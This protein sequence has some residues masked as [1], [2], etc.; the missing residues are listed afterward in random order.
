VARSGNS[1]PGRTLGVLVGIIA[2]LF[3]VVGAGMVFSSAQWTPKLAL[4][5]EG[6]TQIVLAAVPQ[7]GTSGQITQQTLDEAVKIIRQRINGSGV[8]EAEITTQ[9]G[10]NIVVSLPGKTDQATRDSVKRAAAL[11]FRPVLVEQASQPAATAS[12]TGSVSPSASPSGSAKASA[13]PSAAGATLKS[14]AA[15]SASA[16][17]SV[18]ATASSNGMA[19]VQGLLA[20]TPTPSPTTAIPTG[21]ATGAASGAAVASPGTTQPKPT[22]ASDTNWIDASVAEQAQKLD[23]AKQ[24]SLKGVA[25]SDPKKP[26]ATC[27]TDGQAMYILGPAELTGTDIGNAS[28]SL[29]TN[30]QGATGINWQVNLTF[31]NDGPAKF[32]KV[33]SRLTALEAPRNEFAIVLDG[34][35]VSAPRTN[36]AIT[37][38]SAQITGNFTQDQAQALANQLKF[39]ALPISFQELTEQ[40]ISATLGGEQLQRGLL[41]GLIGL[42]LVVLYSLAQYRALGLVTVSSLVIA[43][44]I[45]YGLV[46]LLGWRQGY[47]LSLAGVAGLIVAI[48]ITADSFIVY[49]ERVR[50][51][52]RDGRGLQTAVENAWARARRTILISD[53][54]SFLAA[55][56]L[57]V[58]AIGSVRGFA[59]TLGLTTLI[60]VLV[61]FLFTH[62]MVV[63][64]SRTRFFGGGHRLS[65]FDAEHLGRA[66]TYTGRGR[67]RAHPTPTRA[68]KAATAGAGAAATTGSTIAERRAAA[69]RAEREALMGES[70]TGRTDQDLTPGVAD[71]DAVAGETAGT[72]RRDA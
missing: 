68:T 42:A 44:T 4:D 12:P 55:T 29:E 50:D 61:V 45:T 72:S 51:E 28:A 31:K 46:L 11:E 70:G 20:A 37:G 60:D 9:G 40:N 54:V 19:I 59:F 24:A 21:S 17:P 16:T 36:E 13:S 7:T 52:V 57:Y 53:A 66:V 33:T 41:A 25:S 58:L 43:A 6:G 62:P 10:K 35:V 15:A 48:G 38:G 47:R 64:L 34:L 71:A 23:C 32:A 69:E 65:G 67:A 27:S 5:L 30:S 49:F 18:S 56:V 63:L 26:L 3:G 1:R 2:G 14:S 8:S 39:G 22:D